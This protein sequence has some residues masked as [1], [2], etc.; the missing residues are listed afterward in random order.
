MGQRHA[1]GP[2]ARASTLDDAI[3]W[4]AWCPGARDTRVRE[5]GGQRVSW[6]S[7]RAGTVS[8][9]PSLNVTASGAAPAL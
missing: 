1:R 3:P 9:V 7:E 2:E 8:F 4:H 5:A 6:P